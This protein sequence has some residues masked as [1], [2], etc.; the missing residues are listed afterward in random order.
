MWVPMTFRMETVELTAVFNGATEFPYTAAQLAAALTQ[1]IN[2][3]D[4]NEKIIQ[5]SNE[6]PKRIDLFPELKDLEEV[7]QEE[8]LSQA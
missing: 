3:S 2:N 1:M 8:T 5:D 4:S 7:K 6:D